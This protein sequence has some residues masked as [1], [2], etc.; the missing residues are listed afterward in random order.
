MADISKSLRDIWLTGVKAVN[1]AANSIANTT[2]HKV[3]E[4][5]LQSDR[6]EM[7]EKISNCAYQ[8]WQQGVAFPEEL[9]GLLSELSAIDVELGRLQERF[10]STRGKDENP[11]C[12]I[13]DSDEQ[14][15]DLPEA[16]DAF[17]DDEVVEAADLDIQEA[18]EEKSEE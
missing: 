6:R 3:D 12:E 11:D 18:T 10:S 1:D 7:L 8:L 15:D 13:C 14:P 4:L 17:D 2:R 16:E 5:N 9:D